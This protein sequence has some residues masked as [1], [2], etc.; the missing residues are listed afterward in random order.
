MIIS[1]PAQVSRTEWI[2]ASVRCE[3]GAD[4]TVTVYGV[5]IAAGTCASDSV[6]QAS[7]DVS[8]YPVPSGTA[9]SVS[10]VQSN[11]AGISGTASAEVVIV[12]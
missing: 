3:V 10:F 1:I 9:I 4:L 7:V 5:T 6:W 12:D 8:S 2:S 11:I